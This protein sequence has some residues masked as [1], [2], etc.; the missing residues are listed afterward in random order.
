M[1]ENPYESP[2]GLT[3]VR[4]DADAGAAQLLSPVQA[5]LYVL[6]TTG[7]GALIGLAGGAGLGWLLPS[8][9]RGVFSGG[10]APGFDPLAV[11]IGLGTTQGAGLGAV[12]GVVLILGY[13]WF[14]TRLSRKDS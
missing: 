10:D 5:A 13:W 4:A 9:Y 3:E 1:L 12:V 2:A 14:Q 6:G 7:V 11:G 8:Y